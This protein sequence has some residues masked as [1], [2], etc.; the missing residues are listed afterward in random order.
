[1]NRKITVPQLAWHEDTDMELSFPSSWD[2]TVC[3]MKGHDKAKLDEESIRAAFTHPIGTPP[4]REIAGGR[5]EVAIIF[6]DLARPVKAAELV[7]YILEELSEAGIPDKNIRFI[8]ALG[9]HGAMTRI[10]FAKKLGDEVVERFPVYNHNPYE[11]CTFLGETSSGTPVSLN[12]EVV[13]CDLKIAIG[14]CVPHPTAGFGSGAKLVVPGIASM[15]TIWANHHD[16]GR[17]DR[18]TESDPL[19]K[20]HPSMGIGRVEGN[21]Q[22][23][24]AE[25]IARMLGLD[26]T[27][28]AVMNLKREVVGLFAGDVVA[29][30]REGVKL[31]QKVYTMERVTDMDIVVS[32][33]YGKANES[34]IAI[35][36]GAEPLRQE[37]GDL[38]IIANVPEGQVVH[39][40]AGDFGKTI[41]G[42]MPLQRQALPPRVNRLFVLSAY[43]ERASTYWFGPDESVIWSKTWEEV[44]EQLIIDHPK[45]A[46]VAV[47]P[48]GT[49]QY[50][51]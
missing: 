25:E 46:K 37:G 40:L 36:P 14:S 20:T 49:L 27:V 17:L 32:N 28:N 23:L 1:M 43:V 15:E 39:Y 11:N 50:F 26:F 42:R 10:D 4:L 31:G 35:L 29:A 24:D 5:S 45:G 21:V 22:R 7:P 6:D 41:R 13:A 8:A 3:H 47:I 34:F 16:V 2:V 9:A 33:A 38:V 18:P 19:I 12:S 48:D 30:H 51:E 44:L